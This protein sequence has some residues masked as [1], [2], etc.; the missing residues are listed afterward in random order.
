[1]TK[2]ILDIGNKKQSRGKQN[3]KTLLQTYVDR[4]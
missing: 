2:N 4:G 1:M 3:S